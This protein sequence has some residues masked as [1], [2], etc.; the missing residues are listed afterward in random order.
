MLLNQISKDNVSEY[1]LPNGQA[2][3]YLL[4]QY[5]EIYEFVNERKHRTSTSLKTKTQYTDQE[6]FSGYLFVVLYGT[7]KLLSS[8]TR[9]TFQA[10]INLTT[11]QHATP[12]NTDI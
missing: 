5:S 3:Q 12:A 4:F 7:G 6:W 9:E 2:G 10:G 1:K 8:I 11:Y